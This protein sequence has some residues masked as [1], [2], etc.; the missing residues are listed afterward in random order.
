[1]RWHG[2]TSTMLLLLLHGCSAGGADTCCPPPPPPPSADFARIQDLAQATGGDL[3]PAS[4]DLSCD[5][6]RGFRW[7]GGRCV[8]VRTDPEHCG[9]CNDPCF[10]VPSE[11]FTCCDGQCVG[12]TSDFN[13][14]GACGK[15]CPPQTGTCC[16]GTCLP[17]RGCP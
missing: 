17:M 3:T 10:G 8:D 7:C 13:N 15:A 6:M 11:R 9:R 14:C 1:M 4:P 2:L 16:K 5:W 12:L